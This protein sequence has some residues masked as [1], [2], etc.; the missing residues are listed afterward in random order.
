M[1]KDYTPV[2]LTP[3]MLLFE[4]ELVKHMI[5]EWIHQLGNKQRSNQ[6]Y[7]LFLVEAWITL[8]DMFPCFEQSQWHIN[9]QGKGH[10]KRTAHKVPMPMLIK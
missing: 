9:L 10:M 8:E 1:W 7:D 5:Y 3:L 6:N 4:R 2:P